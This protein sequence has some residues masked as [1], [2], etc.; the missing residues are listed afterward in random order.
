MFIAYLEEQRRGDSLQE[1]DA[2]RVRESFPG[3]VEK[4][5]AFGCGMGPDTGIFGACEG[6]GMS[7]G[8]G[9]LSEL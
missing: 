3:A 5:Q 8:K 6:N 2:R 1:G 4:R 7:Q 9:A